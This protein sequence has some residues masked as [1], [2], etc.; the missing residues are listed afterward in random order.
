MGKVDELLGGAVSSGRVS[1]AVGMVTVHGCPPYLGAFG[2]SA[3]V[4]SAPMSSDTLFRVDGLLRP[5]LAVAALQLVD[6]CMVGLDQPLRTVVPG[7]A[8][9]CVLTGFSPAGRPLLRA[10]R[11]EITLRQVL[12]HTAGLADGSW[13][14]AST[15]LF[16]PRG[17][18]PAGVPGVA[19][20]AD[21]GTRWLHY[22]DIDLVRLVVERLSGM[23][24]VEYLEDEIFRELGMVDTGFDLERRPRHGRWRE[25]GGGG[26]F[27]TPRDFLEF[28]EAVLFRDQSVL[29]P[30]CFELLC[31]N[32]I[33]AL[34]VPA[35]VSL[36]DARTPAD[37]NF[38]PEIRL[39]ST[40]TAK[41]SLGFLVNLDAV[42]GGPE[43]GTLTCAGDAN[44]YC[45]VDPVARVAGLLFTQARP[46]R[47]QTSEVLFGGFQR[48]VY[49]SRRAHGERGQTGN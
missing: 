25:A 15:D 8:D 32:Q 45:W 27:T 31:T 42:P 38:Y 11:S 1:G 3:A 12:S 13:W 28:V 26:F 19:L 2:Q 4:E 36:L 37:L 33:G 17:N 21:P 6:S 40:M 14:G 34:A 9:P 24:V 35:S 48:A 41:W 10:A 44:S 18:L 46:D 30:D 49:A 39:R 47:S 23:T 22:S 29:S 20:L 43:A 16:T 7:L 5:L